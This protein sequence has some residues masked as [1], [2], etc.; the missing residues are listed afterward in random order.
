MD[1][2]TLRPRLIARRAG[3]GSTCR[4]NRRSPPCAKTRPMEL[5][6][7]SVGEPEYVAKP[8]TAS[9]RACSRQPGLGRDEVVAETLVRPFMMIM[10]DECADGSPEVRFAEWHDDIGPGSPSCAS[11]RRTDVACH[12][13]LPNGGISAEIVNSRCRMLPM[14]A[15]G[16][17]DRSGV[18]VKPV[19]LSD[20]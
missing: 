19:D 2:H 20:R 9:H 12:G 16:H 13:T 10:M 18:P 11:Q 17:R 14:L 4:M 5:R 3:R 7:L 1:R 15:V 8:L 6:G